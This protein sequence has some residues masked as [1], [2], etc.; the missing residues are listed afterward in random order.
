MDVMLQFPYRQ[1]GR[2]WM[3]A[4]LLLPTLMDAPFSAIP[5][6]TPSL[7]QDANASLAITIQRHPTTMTE[8]CLLASR[9]HQRLESLFPMMDALCCRTCPTCTDSCCQRAWVWADFRDLLFYHLADITPPEQQLLGRRGERCRYGTPHGCRLD[10]I[11]R[12]FV[13]TWYVCPAQTAI[14]RTH[15]A[16][17]RRLKKALQQIQQ[18]RRQ[19]ENRFVETVF[20]SPHAR[21]GA[22]PPVRG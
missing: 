6:N 13:C 7:W 12:P 16:E 15:P 17:A 1:I 21:T 2:L 4:N 19:L 8:L 20:G 9:M 5:W 18:A 14:L 10:R 22:G 3:A 11:R